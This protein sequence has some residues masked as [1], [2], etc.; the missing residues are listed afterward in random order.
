MKKLRYLLTIILP[1]LIFIFIT[2]NVVNKRTNHFDSLIYK[3]VSRYI[4]PK[5][6]DI[7]IL[8]SFLGSAECLI[9]IALIITVA[10][11]YNEKYTF[12]S[13]MI[14]VNLILSSIIN[15]GMK[16]IIHRDRPNIMKLIEIGGFSY[17]SGHSMVSMSFYG[18]L[19]F[20]CLKNYKTR[21]KYLIMAILSI[22]ILF[23]GLSRIYLGVHYASDVAGGF[24]L[25]ILWLGIFT[26]IVEIRY[27]KMYIQ[28]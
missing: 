19:I 16:Y 10:F 14:A 15:V 7:M 2:Y 12:F 23:I 11:Y 21:W 20:L 3:E 9:V 8:I 4:V 5:L 25:G 28:I 1:I 27:K 13:A 17:P 6:T 18:F 22:L 24:D 26:I